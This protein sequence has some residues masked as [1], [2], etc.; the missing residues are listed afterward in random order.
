[1]EKQVKK[2]EKKVNSMKDGKMKES[3]K[4]DLET[5][6]GKTVLKWVGEE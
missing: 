4:R 6:K 3:L 1:M 5:K 2:I